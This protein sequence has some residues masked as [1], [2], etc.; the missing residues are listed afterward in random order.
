MARLLPRIAFD[1]L[2]TTEVFD[3]GLSPEWAWR[4]LYVE[5]LGRGV[6]VFAVPIRG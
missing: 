1:R 5:W 3:L 6:I 2:S 4:G